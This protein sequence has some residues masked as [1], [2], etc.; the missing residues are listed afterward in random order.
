MHGVKIVVAKQSEPVIRLGS[1]Q[2]MIRVD[3]ANREA[4]QDLLEK[5][6]RYCLKTYGF[7]NTR[8]ILFAERNIA[9]LLTGRAGSTFALKWYLHHNNMKSEFSWTHKHRTEVLYP[10]GWHQ[11][12]GRDVVAGADFTMVRFTRNPFNR[13]V[14]SYLHSNQNEPVFRPIMKHYGR[15]HEAGEG[16]SF[17][18]FL[19][20][21]RAVGPTKVNNHFAMQQSYMEVLH[22]LD[23]YCRIEDG[24]AG[25]NE[26]EV[27]LGLPEST[28]HVYGALRSSP[29]N[30]NYADDVEGSIPDRVFPLAKRKLPYP[31]PDRFYNEQTVSMVLENYAQDFERFGYDTELPD[32][33]PKDRRN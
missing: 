22:E 30:L 20:Y 19:E 9:V 26:L 11:Q 6:G 25:L 15:S 1:L 27:K 12:R 28:Q 29:H 18:D 23:A 21:I 4:T 14:S 33:R 7:A 17:V 2:A 5:G 32:L 10:S 13:A 24:L 8:P 31:S 3:D 16:Y